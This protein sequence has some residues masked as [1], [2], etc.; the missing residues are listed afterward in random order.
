M[1]IQNYDPLW[2]ADM[3]AISRRAYVPRSG[4]EPGAIVLTRGDDVV[5]V[6]RQMVRTVRG[7]VAAVVVSCKGTATVLQW[8]SNLRIRMMP[9]VY[10]GAKIHPGFW[11]VAESLA[12]A[13]TDAIKTVDGPLPTF[14]N[15]LPVFFCGHSRGG[16]VAK[17][18]AFLL[19]KSVGVSGVATFGCPR[20]GD[21]QWAAL[22]NVSLLPRTWS[23]VNHN[24]VVTRLPL[25][26]WGYRHCGRPVYIDR[27]GL[28]H[29]DANMG[30]VWWDRLVG[31]VVA[32]LRRK[33]FDG[34]RDHMA[35]QYAG[36]LSS[37]AT[38]FEEQATQ[39]E[40]TLP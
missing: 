20:V 38:D 1:V 35:M 19:N 21:G 8:V 28:V 37:V 33:R 12:G 31:R 22:Y 7:Q 6:E 2:M 11:E 39:P 25:W 13:V 29:P 4:K 17:C 10:G 9:A 34:V 18:L 14:I 23:A 15:N 5:I 24:D 3:A 30:R 36:T 16:A 27:K 26:R 32:L 40:R